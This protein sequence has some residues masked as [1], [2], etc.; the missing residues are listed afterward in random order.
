MTRFNF[1]TC[2]LC[3]SSFAFLLI[4]KATTKIALL[5]C[6]ALISR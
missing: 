1:V 5:I 4:D 6:S 2:V 3:L